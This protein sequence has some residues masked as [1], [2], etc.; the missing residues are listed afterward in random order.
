MKILLI[1]SKIKCHRDLNLARCN[2]YKNN[3]VNVKHSSVQYEIFVAK[4]TFLFKLLAWQFLTSL[5]IVY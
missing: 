2:I 5:E 4:G 1:T 3:N